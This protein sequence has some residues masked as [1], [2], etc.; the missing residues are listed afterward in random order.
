MITCGHLTFICTLSHTTCQLHTFT[1]GHQLVARI[2]FL[3]AHTLTILSVQ[4][5]GSWALSLAHTTTSRVVKVKVL[6]GT[7]RALVAL[8]TT[9]A[10]VKLLLMWTC[11][12]GWALA[13]ACVMAE[14]LA[15][16]TL[17]HPSTFTL[18]D[19]FV[20]ALH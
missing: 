8:A 14:H 11:E 6:V 13:S 10:G 20:E 4:F 12:C 16:S 15:S 3:V 1:G 5:Q 2:T 18:A 19:L 9:G 7:I 17:L